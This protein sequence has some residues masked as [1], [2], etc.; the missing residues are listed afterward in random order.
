MDI[1]SN[2]CKETESDKVEIQYMYKCSKDFIPAFP[3]SARPKYLD[4]WRM[5]KRISEWPSRSTID[6]IYKSE[7]FVVAKPAVDKP[8]IEKDFCLAYNIHEIKLD[9]CPKQCNAHHISFSKDH[10]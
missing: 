8:E 6:E 1:D 2:G 5:R 3:L 10:S 9:R 7:F 4:A